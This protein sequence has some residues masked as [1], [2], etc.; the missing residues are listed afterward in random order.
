MIDSEGKQ[1]KNSDA[2]VENIFIIMVK[3]I[4]HPCS[5]FVSMFGDLRV[6]CCKYDFI[7]HQTMVYISDSNSKQH[8]S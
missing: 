6:K 1:T 5:S 7:N 8:K 2:Q 3:G 4:Q